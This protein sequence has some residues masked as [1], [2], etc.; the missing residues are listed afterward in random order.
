MNRRPVRVV[1]VEIISLGRVPIT[2]LVVSETS[3]VP[4]KTGFIANA[5]IAANNGR[6]ENNKHA[7]R[8][9]VFF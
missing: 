4:G 7:M 9:G 1:A 5:R 6:K 8:N 3:S 2:G